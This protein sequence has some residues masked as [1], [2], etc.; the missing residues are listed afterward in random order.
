MA[1]FA[2][3]ILLEEAFGAGR[4]WLGLERRLRSYLRCG[5]NVESRGHVGSRVGQM[6]MG[7]VFLVS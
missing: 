1:Y 4:H 7:A 6:T 2:P 5:M 3:L